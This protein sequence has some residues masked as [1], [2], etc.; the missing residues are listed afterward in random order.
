MAGLGEVDLIY[1]GWLA[2]GNCRK[3]R[4]AD[5][6]ACWAGSSLAGWWLRLG[7]TQSLAGSCR[8]CVLP[9]PA[10]A[11]SL[12]VA[13]SAGEAVR[14]AFVQPHAKE[15]LPGKSWRIRLVPDECQIVAAVYVESVV[16][17]GLAPALRLA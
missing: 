16:E 14:P 1:G 13:S 9:C 12:A 17:A 7:L 15:L 10:A 11:A 5:L 6:I 3:D 4:L 2:G 8:C